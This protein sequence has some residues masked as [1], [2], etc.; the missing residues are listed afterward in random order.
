MVAADEGLVL[1]VS[2]PAGICASARLVGRSASKFALFGLDEGMGM[3][4]A[5]R[6]SG[7]GTLVVCPYFVDNGMFAGVGTRLPRLRPILAPLVSWVAR[8]LPVP[9]FD[10]I[11]RFLGL[12]RPMDTFVGHAG[13]SARPPRPKKGGTGHE[14]RA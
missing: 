7:V 10:A 13:A 8:L 2:S 14:H 12:D 11:V 9:W 6:G 1:T 3:E 4:L 5:R